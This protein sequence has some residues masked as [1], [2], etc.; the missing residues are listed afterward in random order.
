M[1]SDSFSGI[2]HSAKFKYYFGGD[3]PYYLFGG[4]IYKYPMKTI[5]PGFGIS[6]RQSQLLNGKQFYLLSIFIFV[7][8][9]DFKFNCI[10]FRFLFQ[11]M[12]NWNKKYFFN[13]IFINVK[14]ILTIN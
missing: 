13:F 6:L 7:G 5:L 9:M 3:S 1:R 10:F 8:W 4:V 14:F 11:K 12:F 2:Y